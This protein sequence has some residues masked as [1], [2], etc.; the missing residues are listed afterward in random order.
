[1]SERLVCL[2]DSIT[3]GI[4]DNRNLGWPGRLGIYLSAKYPDTWHINNLGVAG[5]TSFSLYQRFLSEVLY[6]T[7]QRLIIAG[8]V[9][10]TIRRFWPSGAASKVDIDQ[11]R[12][13]WTFLLLQLK[14]AGI[15]TI[16]LSPLPV[17]EDKMPLIYLPFDNSDQGIRAYNSAISSYNS[18][19]KKLVVQHGF[20]Y[21]DLFEKWQSSE[22]KTLLAD[23]L[24]PNADGY[25]R[26]TKDITDYCESLEFFK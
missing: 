10:D 11:S 9:N 5:D 26:L 19:L 4:G 6:R 7:P 24:H 22:Y 3:E 20:P 25:D 18:M 15:Q 16:F 12:E 14:K 23:G 8:G 2:G 21:L 17:D 1:M 13:N